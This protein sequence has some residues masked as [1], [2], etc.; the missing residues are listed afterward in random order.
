LPARIE[1]KASVKKDLG[2]LDPGTA[3]RVLRKIEKALGG[4]GQQG[5]AL[6]G[7]LSG[8]F[9]LRVGD[10]RVVYART[11]EGY[12]V[13]RIRHRSEVYRPRPGS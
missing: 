4:Q 9:A 10:Y 8:L 11:T 6:A 3:G 5:K 13:L 1:Y 2:H 7:E 12:L